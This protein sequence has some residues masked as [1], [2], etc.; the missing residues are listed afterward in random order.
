MLL[1]S[2]AVGGW[3]GLYSAKNCRPTGSRVVNLTM[4]SNEVSINSQSIIVFYGPLVEIRV[5]C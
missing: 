5:A 2:E 3:T 4:P 1:V